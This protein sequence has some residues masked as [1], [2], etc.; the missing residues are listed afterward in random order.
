MPI[1]LP[2][3]NSQGRGRHTLSSCSLVC[4]NVPCQTTEADCRPKPALSTLRPLGVL[5]APQCVIL[6]KT[7]GGCSLDTTLQGCFTAT[8]MA[9]ASQNGLQRC[10][11]VRMA[12]ASPQVISDVVRTPSLHILKNPL[13]AH[14]LIREAA[15]A[16]SSLN[17]I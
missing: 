5:Q 16:A 14:D 12:G 8:R 4:E 13:P 1:N 15:I 17:W 7:S 6:N 3:L 9:W 2:G 10:Q 11:N